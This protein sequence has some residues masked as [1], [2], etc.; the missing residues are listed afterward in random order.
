MQEFARK[1]NLVDDTLNYQY[2]TPVVEVWNQVKPPSSPDAENISAI[3]ISKTTSLKCLTALAAVVASLKET[4]TT[5]NELNKNNVIGYLRLNLPTIC[6]RG[7]NYSANF[8]ECLEDNV[9]KIL[10]D[11]SANSKNDN[12]I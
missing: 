8:L 4:T 7:D 11:N 2:W 1:L 6:F 3:I 5:M 12:L 10:K 9:N